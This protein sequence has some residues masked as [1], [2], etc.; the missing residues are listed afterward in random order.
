VSRDVCSQQLVTVTVTDTDV[1]VTLR[2][3]D[4]RQLADQENSHKAY[5]GVSVAPSAD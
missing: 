5:Q 3:V 1:H 2:Y 4:S